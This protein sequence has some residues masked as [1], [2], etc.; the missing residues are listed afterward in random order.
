MKLLSLVM[1]ALA[2]AMGLAIV[3]ENGVVTTE[4]TAAPQ[5]GR[6]IVV[7]Q[8]ANGDATSDQSNTGSAAAPNES[9]SKKLSDSK[10]VIHPPPTGDH[11]VVTPPPTETTNKA[12]IP[13]PGTPGGN[14][15]VQPK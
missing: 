4:A 13:P 10:G 12:I 9:P 2:L 8:V 15:N 14:P 1:L 7:D 6:F 11:S 3:D 5:L